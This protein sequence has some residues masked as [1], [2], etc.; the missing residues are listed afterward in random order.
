MERM[1]YVLKSIFFFLLVLLKDDIL[2]YE[3]EELEMFILITS[4][5]LSKSKLRNFIN[6]IVDST[7]DFTELP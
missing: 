2:F 5:K 4:A 6:Y 1:N 3:R 7:R